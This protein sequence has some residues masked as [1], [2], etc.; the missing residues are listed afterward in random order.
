MKNFNIFIHD[1]K[2]IIIIIYVNDIFIAGFNR[3]VINEFKNAFNV[4]F[5][6]MNLKLCIYYLNIKIIRDYQ[7]RIITFN[8][9][10]YL[11]KVFKDYNM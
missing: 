7:N 4:K 11:E 5:R 10:N 9:K 1:K 3:L 2:K 6:I 8:Q